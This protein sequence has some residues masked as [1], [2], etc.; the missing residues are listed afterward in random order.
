MV[1]GC[2]VVDNHELTKA[3]FESLKKTVTDVKRFTFVIIDNNSEVPYNI[4]DY[5]GAKFQVHIVKNTENLGYYYP[6]KQLVEKYP[7]ADYLGLCHNDMVF[8]E[9]GWDHRTEF[10]FVRDGQMGCIGFCGSWAIDRQGGRS[11]GTVCNF[12]G[13][14]GQPQGITGA[15]IGDSKPS[16][17]LDSL[18]MMFRREA[19]AALD[20]DDKIG[21]CHFFDRIWT[22]KMWKNKWRVIVLGIEIDHMGGRTSCSPRYNEDAKAWCAKM[23]LPLLDDN[24]DLTVYKYGEEIYLKQFSEYIPSIVDDNYNVRPHS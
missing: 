15:R 23:G 2:P 8:Y 21:L 11:Y 19:I 16:V 12:R 6:L 7:E 18:F 24:G 17:S 3:L 4:K 20:I 13:E 9:K 14:N 22:L 5:K 1:L 10:E